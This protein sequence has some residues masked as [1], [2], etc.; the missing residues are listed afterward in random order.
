MAFLVH[1]HIA[2]SNYM[3]NVDWPLEVYPEEM[4]S[5]SSI[6]REEKGTSSNYSFL[7]QLKYCQPKT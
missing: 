3:N 7:Y 2:L 1:A 5:G 4:I 6:Q